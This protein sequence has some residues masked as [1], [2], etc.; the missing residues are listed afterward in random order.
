MHGR[1]GQRGIGKGGGEDCLAADALETVA[2]DIGD[3]L[4]C[5]LLPGRKRLPGEGARIGEIDT[6][7]DDH[8]GN[9]QPENGSNQ[10]HRQIPEIAAGPI[11]CMTDTIG[12][13]LNR[14]AQF[15]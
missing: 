6:G 2:F 4:G 11:A 14:S 1:T 9:H 13:G 15:R 12:G 5:D 7:L 10:K 8:I 3:L